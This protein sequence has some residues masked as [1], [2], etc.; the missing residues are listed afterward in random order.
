MLVTCSGDLIHGVGWE[1]L[2]GDMKEDSVNMWWCV[3]LLGE[4]VR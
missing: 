3:E 4:A 2:S 1:G